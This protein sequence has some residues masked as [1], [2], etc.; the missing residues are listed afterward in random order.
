MGVTMSKEYRSAYSDEVYLGGNANPGMIELQQSKYFKRPKLLQGKHF[1]T[2][3]LMTI[4]A[5]VL[6]ECGTTPATSVRATT[7]GVTSITI[8]AVEPLSGLFA[9]QGKN[10]VAGL[11]A[12]ISD[13]NAKGGI[14]ALDGAKLR[15]ITEDA[16]STP[17]TATSAMQSAL[18]AHPVAVVGAWLSS[19][20]EAIQPLAER[21]HI[22]LITEG[23]DDVIT[24]QGYRYT[25][26]YAFPNSQ[27]AGSLLI[28]DV[29]KSLAVDNIKLRRVALVGDNTA[30]ATPLQKAIKSVLQSKGIQ[31]V[32]FSQWTPPLTDSAPIAQAIASSHPD[33]IFMI[34][35]SFNDVYS[36]YTKLRDLGV[37]APVI[38]DGG[39]AIIP[40]WEN[41]GSKLQGLATLVVTSTLNNSGSRKVSAEIA[42]QTGKPF[43]GQ[44]QLDGYFEGQ[45]IAAGLQRAKLASGYALRK[46][47]SNGHFTSGILSQLLPEQQVDFSANGR[48]SNSSG[49]LVQWQQVSGSWTPCVIEPS[50]VAVCKPAW[51]ITRS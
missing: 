46:A 14:A 30:A 33:A 21:A 27:I 12:A 4:G 11:T 1:L 31:V 18:G 9:Q 23:F 13:I 2:V 50:T 19:L 29:I 40:S 15:L 32:Y 48:I 24:S 10:E 39:Q 6:A 41:L 44:D 28:P 17:Q 25:F 3:S 34:A 16:G 45:L 51:T 36:L 43:V 7:S 5:L 38:Q 47:L 8:A 42:R 37:T 49:V 35:Y 26:D 20:T 22:P